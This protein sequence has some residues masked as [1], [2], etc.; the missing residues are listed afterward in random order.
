MARGANESPPVRQE[1]GG[2]IEGHDERPAYRLRAPM[3]PPIPVV[4][5]VP[6]AGRDYPPALLAQMR[7]P[8]H[9]CLRLEDRMIDLVAERVAELTGAV[10]IVA[11][12]P[13]AMLD[14]NR[15]C[16]DI[17]WGMIAG[18]S[19]P[20][21]LHSQ[22]NRR[23][24]S[25]LGLVPRRL[26]GFGEIWRGR[27]T[28]VALEQRIAGI[29]QPYHAA[30][31]RELQH[32]RDQ[33]GAALLIDLHSMPPL[34]AAGEG[35]PPAQFVIGDR[36]GTTCHASLVDCSYR[37]LEARGKSVAHN[38]PYAG[39]Y[40]LDTHAAPANGIH[41]MQLETCRSIYLDSRLEHPTARIGPLADMLAQMVRLLGEET[42]RMGSSGQLR[43]AAE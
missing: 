40:V 4:L 20:A 3:A 10:L 35:M 9:A 6:H 41:A 37:F 22:A 28:R 32:I 27:L 7:D 2:F 12:A 42:A 8:A 34:R 39:G 14:L 16:D 33:W 43:Q 5:A 23:A 31:R 29:H 15:A 19:R 13:R 17:D 26:P 1:E 36:F 24:R 30:T 25:G 38:R 21:T 11:N 18:E